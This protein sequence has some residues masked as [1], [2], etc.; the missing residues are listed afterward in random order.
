MPLGRGQKGPCDLLIHREEITG[1]K[2]GRQKYTVPDTHSDFERMTDGNGM[3]NYSSTS[4]HGPLLI[5]SQIRNVFPGTK[6]KLAIAGVNELTM[7]IVGN[8]YK[9]P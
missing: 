7:G 1:E 3:K 6:K 5:E 9:S 8:S 4:I 2:R